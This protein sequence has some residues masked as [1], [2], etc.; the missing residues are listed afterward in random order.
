MYTIIN[1]VSF[2]MVWYDAQ[3]LQV[4]TYNETL[5][6]SMCVVPPEKFQSGDETARMK[7]MNHAG[8]GAGSCAL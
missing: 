5:T 1:G 6:A 4:N 8:G 2:D 3:S 7:M